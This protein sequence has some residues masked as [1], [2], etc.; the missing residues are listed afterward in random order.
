MRGLRVSALEETITVSRLVGVEVSL[1]SD[2]VA[3]KLLQDDL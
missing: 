2:L 3:C 1:P